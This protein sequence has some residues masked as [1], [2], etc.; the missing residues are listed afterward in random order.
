MNSYFLRRLNGDQKAKLDEGS[1]SYYDFVLGDEQG[2]IVQADVLA[3]ALDILGLRLKSE[4]AS[5]YEGIMLASLQL[6]PL[7]GSE[8]TGSTST[9]SWTGKNQEG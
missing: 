6:P 3:D 4:S 7:P 1:V 8:E 9:G 5:Q 2:V